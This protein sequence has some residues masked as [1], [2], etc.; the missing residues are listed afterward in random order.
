MPDSGAG[1]YEMLDFFVRLPSPLH[2]EPTVAGLRDI[3]VFSDSTEVFIRQVF[4]DNWGQR[5]GWSGL[6]AAVPQFPPAGPC[7]TRTISRKRIQQSW[8]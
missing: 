1:S 5:P 8:W 3:H 4:I 2:D 6:R 7:S